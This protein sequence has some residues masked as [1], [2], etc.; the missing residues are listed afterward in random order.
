MPLSEFALIQRYFSHCGAL[1]ADVSLGVGDDGALLDAPHDQ[2]LVAAIDTLVSGVHFPPDAAPASVGHRALAVNLSDLAAMGASPAWALVA[3]TLPAVDEGWLE[4]FARGFSALA[5]LHGVALVGGDTTKG[6]LSVTVQVMGF[7]PRGKAMLR[8]GGAHGHAL[9]V[10]GTVGDAAA[11]LALEQ[12]RL[13]LADATSAS[14]LRARFAFPTPRTA[15]GIRLRDFAGACIDVSD[16]LLGDAGKLAA[17]SGCGVDLDVDELPLSADLLAALGTEEAQRLALSGGDDYELCFSVSAARVA[18]LERAL[19]AHEWHY[20]RIGALSNVA[21]ARVT[22][23]G[24]VMQ[25]S[26][27]GF[28]HFV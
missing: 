21:G 18:E 27:F 6:P 22:R 17:A 11:G 4:D 7:V 5:Q 23:A 13:I 8:S 15:L 3:L 19:P 12:G 26:H 9:F 16:G 2:T 24:T 28:D 20:R 1:R 10:S 25:F 14:R